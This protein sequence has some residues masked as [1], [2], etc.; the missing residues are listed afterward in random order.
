MKLIIGS[1]N[2]KMKEFLS[3]YDFNS[4]IMLI[5]KMCNVKT[6]K[7]DVDIIIP[8]SSINNIGIVNNTHVHIPELIMSVN[9]KS[10]TYGNI[11]NKNYLESI[12]TSYQIPIKY[13][14]L[15]TLQKRYLI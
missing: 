15:N 1:M 9:V 14:D 2:P 13:L 5:S 6:I 11:N 12:G 3:K 8:F 10:I 4:K 7:G